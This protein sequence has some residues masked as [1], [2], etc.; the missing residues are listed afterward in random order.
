M[1]IQIEELVQLGI[2]NDASALEALYKLTYQ[3]AYYIAKSML[4]NDDDALDI[5]QDSYISA[6]RKLDKL[7]EPSA[8]QSW[9]NKIV[10]NNCKNYMLKK[11]PTLFK[12]SETESLTI[13]NIKDNDE[14]FIPEEF[15][16]KDGK[17]K[18]IMNIIN[19]LSDVQSTT[20]LLF[21]FEQLSLKEIAG[22]MECNESTVTSR[23]SY[24]K[25]YIKT[26]VEKLMKKGEKL[27]GISVALFLSKA[28]AKEAL[29]NT[30]T[31]EASAA[32]YN[33]ISAE[34]NVGAQSPNYENAGDSVKKATK[35]TKAAAI[36]TGL[37]IVAM[38]VVVS[39]IPK[40][41]NNNEIATSNTISQTAETTIM[42]ESNDDLVLSAEQLELLTQIYTYTSGGNYA[43]ASSVLLKNID[44]FRTLFNDT[45]QGEYYLFDG[46]EFEKLNNGEGLVIKKVGDTATVFFGTFVNG[47]PEGRN[48][49]LYISNSDGYPWYRLTE[50]DAW[51]E[52]SV[53][54]FAIDTIEYFDG[55]SEDEAYR[56][57]TEAT[58]INNVANGEIKDTA[59]F[60][61]H[62]DINIF[63]VENGYIVLDDRWEPYDGSEYY[64]MKDDQSSYETNLY[65]DV[66][67]WDS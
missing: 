47:L 33:K 45:M 32:L 55:T 49:R 19:S 29:A 17:R 56:G 15:I 59:F 63:N 7:L 42:E 23:I 40:F 46:M 4:K 30:L 16:E 61:E 54:G 62:S 13:D 8:F 14:D 36:K 20:I 10:V 67:G 22:I 12:D 43:D 5:L 37:A 65:F 2:N 21:Y 35:F 25:K 24:A 51:K 50:S 18:Q 28:F 31:A 52:G 26:E 41:I 39:Q 34:S 58:Y 60:A 53:N 64:T 3:K 27:F 38:G 11:K 57:V 66:F 9:F 1:N 48:L 6:F 44:V